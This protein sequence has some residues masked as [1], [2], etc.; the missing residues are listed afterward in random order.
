MVIF[1]KNNTKW[2]KKFPFILP[3]VADKFL[4]KKNLP[5]LTYDYRCLH[6]ELHEWAIRAVCKINLSGKALLNIIYCFLE[7]V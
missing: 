4:L 1:I 5:C 7:G 6:T 2:N 3:E